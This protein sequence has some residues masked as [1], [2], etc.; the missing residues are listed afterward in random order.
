MIRRPPRSTLF[1]Y[2][3][4]FRS[5]SQV[6]PDGPIPRVLQIQADHLIKPGAAAT[7]HLPQTRD[8]RLDLKHSA[9]VP[10]I[11]RSEEHTSELQLLA[12]LVCRLLLGKKKQMTKST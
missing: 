4:L 10:Q 5:N 3:T 12:Y 11:I 7:L 1:P 6:Q 9:A 8:S 2:T